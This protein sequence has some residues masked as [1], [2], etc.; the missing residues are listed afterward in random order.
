MNF[1]EA[2][3]MPKGTKFNVNNRVITKV[4]STWVD[5]VSGNPVYGISTENF[6]IVAKDKPKAPALKKVVIT[7]KAPVKSKKVKKKK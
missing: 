3:R 6:E 1:S 2:S 5:D 4:D 7:A